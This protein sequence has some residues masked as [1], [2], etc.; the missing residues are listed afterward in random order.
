MEIDSWKRLGRV[1]APKSA[2][3]GVRLPFSEATVMGSSS[4][5]RIM[6]FSSPST[7]VPSSLSK[8]FSLL[9]WATVH[10][11]ACGTRNSHGLSGS[12]TPIQNWA[13]RLGMTTI[14]PACPPRI[15]T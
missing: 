11:R 15:T 7:I 1:T 6:S 5:S 12:V 3:R 4:E 14:R 2:L 9:E 8:T 10:T 13:I